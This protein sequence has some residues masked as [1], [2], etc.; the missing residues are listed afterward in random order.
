V[1]KPILIRRVEDHDGT[2][3]F[4]GRPSSTRAI[5]DTTA[6]LMSTMMA[7]VINAGT[8]ARA[9]S[10]GFTLPAAGKTGTTNDFNDAWFI[11]FT[12][13]LA[14]GVWVG[15]DQPRTILPNGFAA[16][17]AVP[18]WAKFMKTATQG[19]KPDWISPPAGIVTAS[20][21]RLTGKLATEQCRDADV[22]NKYGEVERRSTV[23]TEYFARGT[24]PTTYCDGHQPRVDMLRM[25]DDLGVRQQPATQASVPTVPPPTTTGTAG[26]TVTQGTTGTTIQSV[27][28]T[29]APSS[30]KRSFWW[31]LLGRGRDK[32][33][34]EDPPP[35]PPK[36]PEGG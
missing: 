16:D 29:Q 3:L 6:F 32:S 17:I 12:P 34:K 7:D 28:G 2:V 11:G 31:R 23:Y 4:E 30:G 10:L 26:T 8:A 1:P 19:D 22:V 20:V 5:S 13:K 21:C 9:R 15:F 24:E 14:T 25:A 35:P 36:R 18:V 33:P 27:E